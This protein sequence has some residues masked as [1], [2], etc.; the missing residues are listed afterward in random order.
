MSMQIPPPDKADVLRAF[1]EQLDRELSALVASARAAHEAATHEET[2]AEDR[3]DTFAIEASY[4]A[5]GQSVRV[6]ELEQLKA[7]LEG[8]LSGTPRQSV[9]GPGALVGYE[10]EDGRH[11]VL[12][13]R[14]GGGLKGVV[15]GMPVQILSTDSPLGGEFVGLGV[16]EEF[17]VEIRGAVREFKILSID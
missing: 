15:Q 13:V 10:T 7:E 3:H 9:V 6:S 4:L 14:A 8:Y 11:L 1:L 17:E 5:A 16:G 2:K 12:M